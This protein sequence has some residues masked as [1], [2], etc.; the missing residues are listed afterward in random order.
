MKY[1]STED[2]SFAFIDS[3]GEYS[4]I[5]MKAGMIVYLQSIDQSSQ[6]VHLANENQQLFALSCKTFE[7]KFRKEE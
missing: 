7:E 4:F 6:L 2:I 1:I 3:D 5:T